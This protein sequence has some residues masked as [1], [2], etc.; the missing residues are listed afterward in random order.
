MT[1]L[2]RLALAAAA[3]A[4]ACSSDDQE[5][6]QPAQTESAEDSSST[7]P[8]ETG[9]SSG[10]SEACVEDDFVAMGPFA[11]PGWDGMGAVI[12]EPQDSYIAHGT[13]LK[14]KPDQA[15]QDQFFATT[16]SVTQQLD[17]HDGLIGY[18]VGVSFK[19]GTA[20]TLG[21][22][23]DQDAVTEFV[24]SGAHVEA[25]GMFVQV[26]DDGRTDTWAV[27]AAGLP[28]TFEQ[29]AEQLGI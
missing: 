3:L 17:A 10:G 19:C 21:V 22:W 28:P 6:P 18:Q 12:G 26:A 7:T 11:G 14:M 5:E 24:Y 23:R 8:G 4:C 1:H 13:W 20:R 9:S 2:K 15:S 16:A 29:A 27:D 25:I